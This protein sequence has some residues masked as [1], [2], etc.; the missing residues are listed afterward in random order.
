MK[1]KKTFVILGAPRG[2]TSMVGG[3]LRLFGIF[4]G[5]S[6]SGSYG[7]KHEDTEFYKSKTKKERIGL[8]NKRNEEHEVW[9]F[10]DPKVT[11]YLHEIEKELIN[12]HYIVITR[13]PIPSAKSAAKRNKNQTFEGAFYRSVVINDLLNKFME[14]NEGKCIHFTYEDCL[15]HPANFVETLEVY[16]DIKLSKEQKQTAI[17][18]I[19]PGYKSLLEYKME[20]N[21]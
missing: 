3:L 1:T 8:I 19:S 15:E 21:K 2:G 6:I 5:D 14:S 10:K 12:P 11:R 20:W 13:E 9:G 17:N 7:D 4:M 18:F 16:L